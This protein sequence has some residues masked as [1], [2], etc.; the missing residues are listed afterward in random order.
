MPKGVSEIS[1]L[2]PV[3]WEHKT[4]CSQ[5]FKDVAKGKSKIETDLKIK[6]LTQMTCVSLYKVFWG[7]RHTS[8]PRHSQPHVPWLFGIYTLHLPTPHARQETGGGTEHKSPKTK[9]CVL[10]AYRL[11]TGTYSIHT[12]T[13]GKSATS[14]GKGLHK[15]LDKTVVWE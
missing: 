8:W 14:S 10:N 2:S 4:R 11:C 13:Q 7:S 15:A 1:F 12:R 9:V 5:F 3:I 6:A